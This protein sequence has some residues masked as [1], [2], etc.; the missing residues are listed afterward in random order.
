ME[1]KSG[2]EKK[3]KLDVSGS[4]RGCKEGSGSRWK[5]MEKEVEVKDLTDARGKWE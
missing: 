3:Q 1:K 5:L 4:I 2:S